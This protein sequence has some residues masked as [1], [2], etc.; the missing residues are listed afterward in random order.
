VTALTQRELALFP[1]ASAQA[2]RRRDLSDKALT[3]PLA[4]G[5][6][7]RLQE[8]AGPTPCRHLLVAGAPGG[9]GKGR[10]LRTVF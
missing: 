5:R 7:G 6:V 2:R 8:A 4:E 9:A 10:P 1:G 3:P